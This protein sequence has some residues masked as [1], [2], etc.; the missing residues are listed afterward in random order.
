[1]KSKTDR[2]CSEFK[3]EQKSTG[4]RYRVL[5]DYGNFLRMEDE[6]GKEPIIS[7]NNFF[8]NFVGHYNDQ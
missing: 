4:K 3:Y 5:A 8:E 1:M 2:T 7:V 6:Q